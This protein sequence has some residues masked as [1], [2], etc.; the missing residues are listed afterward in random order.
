MHLCRT[1][2]SLGAV[3]TEV[4]FNGV[5]TVTSE[6][7]EYLKIS[8][9]N[10]STN[11]TSSISVF[12]GLEYIIAYYDIGTNSTRQITGLVTKIYNDQIRI[13][14]APTDNNTKFICNKDNCSSCSNYSACLEA[15]KFSNNTTNDTT[16]LAACNCIFNPPNIDK[17]DEPKVIFVPVQNIIAINYVKGNCRCNNGSNN[18][19][20]TGEE[21][22]RVM[23]L[24]ITANIVKAIV[25][26]LDFIEENLDEALK[27]VELHTGGIYDLTYVTRDDSCLNGGKCGYT[28]YQS[29]VKLM[30]IQ[31]IDDESCPCNHKAGYVREH[32]GCCNA[33]YTSC[34]HDKDDFMKAE[35][36][37]KIRLIVD[38][39]ETFEGRYES[40]MLDCVRDCTEVDEMGNPKPF[41]EYDDICKCCP[42]KCEGC[43]PESCGQH[44]TP[45]QGGSSDPTI[46]T[47]GSSSSCGCGSTKTYEYSYTDADNSYKASVTGESVVLTIKGTDT[48]LTLDELI[49]YYLG[50]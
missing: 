23:L 26:R 50:L 30:E 21:N 29:R 22:I 48:K 6:L 13:K 39:S 42:H 49:K 8:F 33:V 14:V 27:Y 40:I 20:N 32:V 18:N 44:N 31:E 1:N 43:N 41:I 16:S 35:P 37:R 36:V 45:G 19:T 4:K 15:G 3:G 28:T 10:P 47:P 34:H 24:G 46:P 2:Q 38:T 9:F 7:G 11:K 5:Q 25:I 17:Y 12:S